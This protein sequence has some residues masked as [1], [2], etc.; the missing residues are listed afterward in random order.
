MKECIPSRLAKLILKKSFCPG[1]KQKDAQA[2]HTRLRILQA[3]FDEMYEHGY[4]GMRIENILKKTK[5]AKGALYHH[6]SGKQAL[7]YA[8]ADEVLYQQVEVVWQPLTQSNDPITDFC[9][10]LRDMCDS[11]TA[12]DIEKGCPI[13]NLAQEMAGLDQGFNQRLNVIYQHWIDTIGNALKNGQKHHA[14]RADI[15]PDTV[16]IFIVST[17]QGAMGIAKCM[18]SQVTLQQLTQTLCEYLEQLRPTEVIASIKK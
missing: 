16:S 1:L 2:E 9:L 6:F 17:I 8:V 7:G 15:S 4:Q 11:A 12:K 3:A 10:L 5:L 13:N 18:Q 14:V